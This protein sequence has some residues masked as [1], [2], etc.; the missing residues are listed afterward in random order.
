MIRFLNW[1]NGWRYDCDGWLVRARRAS[2]PDIRHFDDTGAV[3]FTEESCVVVR[4]A[5]LARAIDKG[6]MEWP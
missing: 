1:W 2:D 3:G 4:T 6:T 5:E